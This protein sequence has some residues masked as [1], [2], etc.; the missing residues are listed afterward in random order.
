[1]SSIWKNVCYLQQKKIISLRYAE[2]R[3]RESK[4]HKD[5]KAAKV[6]KIHK[7]EENNDYD[8]EESIYNAEI[9]KVKVIF[10]QKFRSMIQKTKIMFR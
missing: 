2:G 3:V 10:L 9:S 4:S 6:K 7:V 1:M 5:Y 8:S